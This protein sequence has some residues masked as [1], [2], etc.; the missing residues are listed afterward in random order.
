MA[1]AVQSLPLLPIPAA[2]RAALSGLSDDAVRKWVVARAEEYRNFALA[3]LSVY[4]AVAPIHRAFPTE[5]LSEVFSHCWQDTH[6]MAVAHVCRHW[7]AI[8]LK[9]PRLWSA[10]ITA[11]DKLTSARSF[12]PHAPFQSRIDFA[13]LAFTRS[14][15]EPLRIK[16]LHFSRDFA[17]AL[18][19]HVA[20][21]VDLYV[22]LSD[23]YR[24]DC[25]C[26]FL[27]AGAP[28]LETLGI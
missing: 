25:L 3:L 15:P 12:N 19:P 22:R 16:L 7:R 17:N 4:N 28:T 2:D 18:T 21:L 26:R 20:R 9:T 10:A 11:P 1:V 8:A 23:A 24:L 27:A 6:F 13:S 5:I 14:S